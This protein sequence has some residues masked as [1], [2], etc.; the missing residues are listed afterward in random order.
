[1]KLIGPIDDDKSVITKDYVDGVAE[2][3]ANVAEL[4]GVESSTTAT[5]AYS[6]NDYLQ[7]V[8]S[9]GAVRLARVI[10]AIAVGDTLTLNTNIVDTTVGSEIAAV[11]RKEITLHYQDYMNL[12]AAEKNDPTKFY[13]IDDVTVTS[14]D[15]NDSAV[16]QDSTW[17]SSKINSEISRVGG[18]LGGLSDTSISNP[19]DGQALL[20]DGTN[21][22]WVNGDVSSTL[23]ELTDTN[24]S[25]PSNG[26]VLKYNS[27]SS[28]WVNSAPDAPTW[29]GI[30]GTL[31]DQT[32]LKNAL[33][34]K[35]DVVDVA[36]VNG[37]ICQTFTE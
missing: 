3:K 34:R 10:A 16:A 33:D 18:S 14:V 25:N 22:E 23:T 31:S 9:N 21:D 27:S 8:D 12:S 1:M 2:V 17:S 24:I 19:S 20:Y 37:M 4:A 29:G 30:T 7:Y 11:N 6:V 36:I 35:Q 26:N 13:Y 5:L 32:D 28:K 15:I